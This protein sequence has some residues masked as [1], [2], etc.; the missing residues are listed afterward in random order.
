GVL[1]LRGKHGAGGERQHGAENERRGGGK[2]P[3]PALE[4]R[5]FRGGEAP[6]AR[7]LG[8]VAAGGQQI[9]REV[10]GGGVA[11]LGVLGEAALDDPSQGGRSFRVQLSDGLGL[12]SQDRDER[13]GA[14]LPV[15]GALARRHLIEDRAERELVGAEVEWLTSRLLRRHVARRAHDRAGLRRGLDR[16]W[17]LG[18]LRAARLG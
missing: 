12:L 15:E 18:A 2:K 7:D 11:L 13:L 10:L 8:E 3:A 17:K 16:R 9:A 6:R 4:R 5:R 1:R 14:G